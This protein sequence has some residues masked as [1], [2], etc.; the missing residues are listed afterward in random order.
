MI[1][2]LREVKNDLFSSKAVSILSIGLVM[3][4]LLVILEISFAAMLF[5][6]ELSDYAIPGAGI[7]LFGALIM[8]FVMALSSSFKSVVALPQDAPVAV[9]A[10]VAVSVAAAMPA[11]SGEAKFITIVALMGVSSLSTA[12]TFAIIGRF[13]LANL[14]RY[15]P[16]PVV[17]GFL[18]GSGWLL[19]AGGISVMCGISPG[20]DTLPQ[21]MTP[22]AMWK[23]VPGVV[24][25]GGLFLLMKRW[26]HFTLLPGSMVVC[27]AAFYL[28]FA[29]AGYSTSDAQQAG[30]LL[31]GIPSQGLWPAFSLPDLAHID[32]SVA[33]GQ[34]PSIATVVLVTMVM[35]LLNISGVELASGV[36]ID[37]NREFSAAGFA[38]TLSGLSGCHPGTPALSLS[39]LAYKI[40]G[41][42]RLVGLTAAVVV[43]AVLFLGG[44][45]MGFIPK[46]LLGGLLLLLGLSFIDDWIVAMWHKLPRSDYAIVFSIF[47]FIG[48]VGFLEGVVFGLVLTI[49][50]FVVRF[51]RVSVVQEEF[52]AEN[53]RSKKV[54]SIPHE[55]ILSSD[56]DR[57]RG[58]RLGGYI[59]FGSAT[60]LGVHLREALDRDPVPRC[61]LLDFAN[62]TGFDISAV[63][64]IQRFIAAARSKGTRVVF[65]ATSSW[66]AHSLE[67][68]LAPDDMERL[69]MAPDLDRGL[70]W[71]EELLIDRYA[72]RIGKE[73]GVRA[74]LFE[75]SVDAAMDHLDRQAVF[76][77]LAE[78]LEPWGLPER[79]PAGALI[80]KAGDLLTGLRLLV[81]GQATE[82]TPKGHTRLRA[83]NPGAVFGA[84]AAFEQQ[85][86][87]TEVKADVECRTIFLPLEQMEKLAQEDPRLAL[88]LQRHLILEE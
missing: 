70:E 80:I 28:A 54:R 76:E 79:H 41:S 26:S 81:W 49:V 20:L 4:V 84:K 62:V 2:V 21:M 10:T 8:S 30:F 86:A 45:A 61:M 23:W 15:M 68:N 57:V 9:L 11:A 16:Y 58:Y 14:L 17:G 48:L 74:A 35:Q 22:A 78:R 18:A 27:A 87:T 24:Y 51:S 73:K 42:A 53:R 85:T 7:T 29:A 64:H 25:G 13:R 6:G 88:D 47:L 67:R 82:R 39:A 43:A 83:C 3:G 32:W 44:G 59:F 55:T 36:E 60:T 65:A 1:A 33:M 50:F 34:L 12:L 38:N 5:T 37:M 40:A 63:N 77:V 71:A 56:G 31:S 19:T 66:L 75:G 52:T 72:S 69:Y 46:P